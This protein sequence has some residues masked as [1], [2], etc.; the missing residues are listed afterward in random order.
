MADDARLICASAALAEGGRGVRFALRAPEGAQHG[1]AIRSCG[2][3]R[4]YVNRCPH[5]GTELDWQPGEFFDVAGLYLI[6]STHGAMFEPGTGHC[7]AGP[8]RGASLERL[9]VRECDGRVLLV[10]DAAI[11]RGEPDAP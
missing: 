6:C 8:C 2:A 1:F 5:L 3:V 7:V 9:D 11:N 10:G 4:A